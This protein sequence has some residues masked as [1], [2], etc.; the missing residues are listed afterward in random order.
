QPGESGISQGRRPPNW[1]RRYW[2][3]QP[4]HRS[5]SPGNFSLVPV[6]SRKNKRIC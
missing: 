4:L 3:V 1:D 2:A 5:R 6:G